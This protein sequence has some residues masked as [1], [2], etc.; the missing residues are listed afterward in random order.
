M[1]DLVLHAALHIANSVIRHDVQGHVQDG[2]RAHARLHA[3]I[4]VQADPDMFLLTIARKLGRTRA[5]A[6]MIT[7]E[8]IDL[9]CR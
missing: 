3:L 6:V 7:P 2:D 8:A 4:D 9:A 5:L 1:T